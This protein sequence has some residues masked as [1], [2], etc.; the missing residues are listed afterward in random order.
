VRAMSESD[1]PTLP[2]RSANGEISRRKAL[3]L[4]GGTS[5]AAVIVPRLGLADAAFGARD[6]SRQPAEL[7]AARSI[8]P[9]A[10]S[11]SLV[12]QAIRVQDMINLEFRFYNAHK[13]VTNGQTFVAPIDASQPAFMVVVFPSQHL[14][15]ESVEFMSGMTTWPDPPALRGALAGPS[16]LAFQVPAH[17]PIPFTLDGLLGWTPFRPQLVSAATRP[18]GTPAMP[19]SMHSALEVPWGL[20]LTPPANGTWHHS[21][22]PV[23]ANGLTELWHTRLGLRGAEPPAVTPPVKAFWTAGFGGKTGPPS[24]PWFMSLTP[25]DRDNIVSLTCSVVSGGGPASADLLAL[26]ALGASI[27]LGAK[28]SPPANSGI[29][30]I[31][32]V[33]RTSIGRDSYVRTVNLGY[34]FPF[35]HRAVKITITDREFQVDTSGATVA[36]LV[37]KVYIVVTE[38]VISFAGD[39]HEPFGGRGNPIRTIKVKTLTT[40]PIDFVPAQDPEIEVGDLTGTNPDP[41]ILWVRSGNEDVPFAFVA[42]DVE[43]RTVDFTAS[44]IW[45]DESLA[46]SAEINEIIS[47]YD[48]APTPRNTPS[49]GGTLF[50][51]AAPGSKPGSTAQHVDG[52]TLTAKFSAN[53]A[54][55]FY[56]LLNR[57]T[58]HL[59]GAEQLTGTG[60]TPLP[61]PSVSFFEPYL[62]SG[63]SAAVGS[64]N[65]RADVP[66]TTSPTEIFLQVEQNAPGLGFPVDLIGG[67]AGPNFDVTGLS[68]SLGPVGGSLENLLLGNFIPNQ[69]F[70]VLSGGIGKLLG[71]IP[72][73]EIIEPVFAVSAAGNGPAGPTD[74]PTAFSQ[75]PQLSY[76]FVYPNNDASMPPTALDAKLT[77]NPLVTGRNTEGFFVPNSGGTTNFLVTAEIF[78]PISN[79]A[80]TTYTIHGE[81][82]HFELV[83]FGTSFPAI[84]IT[85]SSLIFDSRTGAKTSLQPTIDSVS[86]MGPL[87]FIAA[88]GNLLSSLGSPSVDVTAAG[89]D[90][91]YT[92]ALPSFGVGIFSLSNL[93]LS[94]GVNIPLDGTPVRMRFNLSTQDNP[95]QLTI[96][97]FGGGGFF[98]LAIG[99]DGIE[100]IQVQLEFGA[101]VSINLGVASGGVSIMAGIYYSYVHQS[102]PPTDQV[103]LTGFVRADGNLS[104]LG[105]ITLSMEFYLG[106][107]YL[108]PGECFGEATVTVSVKVL[109]FS[110]SVSAT[111][112]KTFGGGSDPDF[113]DAISQPDWASY[114]EAF[115]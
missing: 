100:E 16:W 106:L 59:P 43:N 73:N 111:M 6:M 1:Q 109:F 64:E 113:R 62:T 21:S 46:T 45:L 68:R 32:W 71:A 35:G 22:S 78:A 61:A 53:G 48:A 65:G 115:G 31:E 55:N 23:T 67:I 27:N 29:S 70:S 33:H 10:G 112:Q 41:L 12:F 15:E 58:V 108:S 103:M 87:S 4:I 39:P 81:L 5:A 77:W 99:A 80:G 7:L 44:V 105:M 24:D 75:A 114:C 25:E 96:Y 90:A 19:D 57:A 74:M 18:N 3:E 13:I 34:L 38:P 86:F 30:L 92:L 60:A 56:P 14:G 84:G 28:W 63:F 8:T 94:A 110:A 42:T 20:W 83:V 97:V 51:F 9:A 95:F 89:I 49:F 2:S 17:P 93:S 79:P 66:A 52:Y 82:T 40:A 36:Y 54:A 37:T 88:M 26:S 69:Y 47:F 98:S 107:T 102:T 11:P 104:V 91:S 50:A 101:A 85:F 76:S 72:V